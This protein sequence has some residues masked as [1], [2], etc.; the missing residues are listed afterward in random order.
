MR[1]EVKAYV[2]AYVYIRCIYSAVA[3]RFFLEGLQEE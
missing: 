2:N 3:T 1:L